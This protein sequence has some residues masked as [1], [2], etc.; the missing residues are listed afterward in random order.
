VIPELE[1]DQYTLH[2]HHKASYLFQP[3][4]AVWQAVRH[5][6]ELTKDV[7]A[8][9]I[10]ASKGFTDSTK[11]RVQIRNGREVKSFT[12]AFAKAYSERLGKTINEQL[13]SSA[14]LIADFWYTAWVDAGKP[15]LSKLLSKPFERYDRKAMK[16]EF[17]AY[18]K[19][20]LLE[21]KLLIA[22]QITN[23]SGQ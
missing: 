14:D 18:R 10:E 8:Q 12:P 19:G 1:L 5:A 7:F 17:K 16:K 4:L 6:Y 15:D 11:F 22:R 2:D 20:E 3:E 9:E 13:L 21:K 23:N